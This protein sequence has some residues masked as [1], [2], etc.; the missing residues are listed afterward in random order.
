MLNSLASVYHPGGYP[1]QTIGGESL[2]LLA[3]FTV[4][5][6][7]GIFYIKNRVYRTLISLSYF[8]SFAVLLY[9]YAIGRG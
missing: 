7:V 5:F 4:I 6:V 1:L 2:K 3:I 8:V 9:L